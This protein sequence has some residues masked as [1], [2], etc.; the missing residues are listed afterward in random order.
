[1]NIMVISNQFF[2]DQMALILGS[3][4]QLPVKAWCCYNNFH[5]IIPRELNTV[6]HDSLEGI[7]SWTL[8][9]GIT[10]ALPKGP[11]YKP[12]DQQGQ[13]FDKVPQIYPVHQ[14]II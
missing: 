2:C 13:R 6:P 4:N 10:N 12:Q 5:N 9:P 8:E 3:A 14:I 1:M 7:D 11:G